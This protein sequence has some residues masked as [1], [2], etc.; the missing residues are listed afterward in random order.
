MSVT[1]DFT[2]I[3]TGLY[4]K[5]TTTA[6]TALWAARVYADQAPDQAAAPYVRFFHV[7][8]GDDN[9]NPAGSFDVDYQVE[10]WSTSLPQARQGMTY[11]N[12]ALHHQTLTLSGATNYWTVQRDLI[13]SV[14]NVAG[15]QWYR[16][17]A[18]YQIKG[19]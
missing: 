8:G 10:C 18:T 16:R 6:G 3:E 13:R 12:A 4:S 9:N 1:A 5:L 7:G 17:G 19:S 11:I 2:V 15:V 14:E